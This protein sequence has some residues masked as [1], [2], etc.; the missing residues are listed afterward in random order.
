MIFYH[1]TTTARLPDILDAGL[2]P[3]AAH[4]NPDRTCIYLTN[5]LSIAELYADLA[6]IRRGGT[7]VIIE[8]DDQ[9][10]SRQLFESDDYDLQKSIDD[11]HD[12]ERTDQIGFV[13]GEEVDERL[14]PFRRWQDVPAALCLAVTKQI[15]FTDTIPPTAF[16]N[17]DQLSTLL[18]LESAPRSTMAPAP[19][20]I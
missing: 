12:P 8:I 9:F 5:S 19:R 13:T 14:L 17:I 7:P 15:A 1:G 4:D 16:N 11:L 3:Q 18:G 2:V 10:L 6:S 20:P